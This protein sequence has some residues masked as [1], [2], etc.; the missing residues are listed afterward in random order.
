MDTDDDVFKRGP[1]D[2]VSYRSTQMLQ[3]NMA[4]ITEILTFMVDAVNKIWII[5]GQAASFPDKA[6]DLSLGQKDQWEGWTQVTEDDWILT[7]RH[8]AVNELLPGD[9]AIVVSVLASEEIHD[10]RLVVVHPVHVASAPLVEIKV[11]HLLKLK[12][13]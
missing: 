3:T 12:M 11:L 10:A 1:S 7:G 5:C 13:S 2:A 6:C 4:S 8:D 9:L